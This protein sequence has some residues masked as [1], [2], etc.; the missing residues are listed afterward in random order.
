[1]NIEPIPVVDLF[2]GPGGLGEGFSSLTLD[3]QRGFKIVLSVEKDGCAHSTLTL[4]AF[5]RQFPRGE[6]PDDYYDY[7]RGSISRDELFRR[8]PGAAAAAQDEARLMTLGVDDPTDLISS[9]IADHKRWILI[10]GPPCQAYSLVGRSRM[11]GGIQRLPGESDAEYRKR[12]SEEFSTDHRHELYRQ[13]LKI[14]AR[15]WPSIF[16]MENV[17]GILSSEFH[18]DKIFPR[19]LD[20]LRDPA[21]VFPSGGKHFQYRIF[22]LAHALDSKTGTARPD[23]YLVK[24]ELYGIPQARHRVILVGVRSDLGIDQ[25]PLLVPEREL[26]VRDVLDDLPPLSSGLSRK[27]KK[28]PVEALKEIL[29]QPV[30]GLAKSA[31]QSRLF[32]RMREMLDL[33]IAEERRGGRFVASGSVAADGW[34]RDSRLGGYCNH[35][36]RSHIKED[37]WRYFFAACYAK[38]HGRSPLLRDFPLLLLPSHRNVSAGVK[39]NKFG[40][41]FRVQIENR[42]ATTVTS[43][44]SKD[45][46]YFIHYDPRQY[47]CLTVR[48]AAR[49]QTFPDNY[50]FE[51]PRTE[52]YH[53]VGNAVPPL[54]A[55]KIAEIVFKTLSSVQLR[56][57]FPL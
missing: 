4:R 54:L 48:E 55:K 14:I 11:L 2:A 36:S 13:Y 50:F 19:I 34:F 18:G 23:D 33:A 46:H 10:G 40:D 45:G 30:E 20:D 32:E 56:P 12:R 44:I 26:T 28:A 51:G 37:L 25:I 17:R 15:F 39:D 22:S 27:T 53:Q 16:V 47:R 9:R 8:W 49:L 31:T 7:L 24:S 21:S 29:K 3:E 38:V 42:P 41:R 57:E 43:H 35:E 52:Q 1:M 6:A 5:F